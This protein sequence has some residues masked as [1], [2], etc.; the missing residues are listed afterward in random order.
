[1]TVG[2]DYVHDLMTRTKEDPSVN[3]TYNA[4]DIHDENIYR[5]MDNSHDGTGGFRNGSYLIPHER[6]MF[7]DSRRQ[8]AFYKN[9]VKPIVRAMIE[10][11][12]SDPVPRTITTEG[13]AILENTMFGDFLENA[14]NTG[15]SMQQITE[16]VVRNARLHGISFLVMDNFG[17]ERQPR[18][19]SEARQ[20]RIFPYVYIRKPYHVLAYKANRFGGLLS[21]T[22]EDL[23]EL[24]SKEEGKDR[25]VE[26]RAREL[27]AEEIITY[28]IDDN[29][30]WEEL[31]RVSHPLKRIP[32]IVVY[33]VKMQGADKLLPDPPLYDLATVNHAIYNKD[34]EIRYQER[35]QGFA[36]FYVQT[37]NTGN[38]TIGEKNVLFVS[39]DASM[40][41]GFASPDPSILG[42]LVENNDKLREDL[43]RIAEQNG[44]T[45]VQS[46]KSGVAIQWDFFAHESVLKKSSS[47]AVWIEQQVAEYFRLWTGEAFVYTADYPEDFQPNDKLEELKLYDIYLMMDVPPKAKAL[48]KAKASR[49]IFSDEDP[50][51]VAAVVKEIEMQGEDEERGAAEDERRRSGGSAEEENEDEGSPMEE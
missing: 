25:K 31:S 45:G 28:R 11:V 47:M 8:L 50:T 51:V 1:M 10:P 5:F 46:A 49:L 44:V 24:V 20:Q 22:F 4:K 38:L 36:V 43:F 41:P 48:A 26:R 9:F 32:V 42:G 17:E 7:Y 3:D 14:D 30:K 21:I 29:D 34:S 27:T 12:F 15:S 13:G 39:M 37:E 18:L 2:E 35:A 16:Q 40:P 6:E 23:P 19:L 33:S